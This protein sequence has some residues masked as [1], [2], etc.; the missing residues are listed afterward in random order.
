M[1]TLPT[2]SKSRRW[3]SLKQAAEYIGID[4]ARTIRRWISEG[5]ITGYKLNQR[6]LRVDLNEIDSAMT[7][8]GGGV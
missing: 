6:V 8:V 1:G 4:D 3:A 5:R 2:Q 7:P